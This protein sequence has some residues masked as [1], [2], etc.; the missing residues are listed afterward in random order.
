MDMGLE[1][2]AMIRLFGKGSKEGLRKKILSEAKKMFEA[3]SEKDFI[4]IHSSFCSWGIN[5]IF[6]AE[7]R[8][9]GRIL[10]KVF[11]ASYGQIAKT[12]DVV[13]KVAI[14]YCH[15]P[16]CEKSQEI[17][18]W[19]N[20][21]VDTKMMAMLR[22]YYPKDIQSW[23]ITIE[24]VD[25]STYVAIQRIVRKYIREKHK[26]TITPVQFDDIYW[27]VLN[28]PDAS[29]YNL[30][31]SLVPEKKSSR[32]YGEVAVLTNHDRFVQA[33]KGMGGKE[34]STSE[35]K[36]IIIGIFPDMNQRSIL[37]NDHASGNKSP[38]WCAG[39]D[40]RVFDRI[41]HGRYRVR[42][43]LI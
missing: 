19:L 21:A 15:L 8:R 41:T 1:F 39:S 35:I 13:L 30:Q 7:K 36:A 38:C 27:K 26:D 34:L 40:K 25:R 23:P 12:L 20:A 5:N 3:K 16:N 6:L 43:S 28:R 14:Y 18:G 31:T 9:N 17:S 24:Q 11:P 37:P 22:K 42:T 2:S 10:K 4:D 32:F 29:Q 33:F